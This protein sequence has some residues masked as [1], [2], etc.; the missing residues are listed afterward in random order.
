[1]SGTTEAE[2]KK[3]RRREKPR[4]KEDNQLH[5]ELCNPFYTTYLSKYSDNQL[6]F[7]HVSIMLRF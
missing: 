2:R 6:L 4:F 3:V 7:D 5:L 1:M